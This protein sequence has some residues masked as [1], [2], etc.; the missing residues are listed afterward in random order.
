MKNIAIIPARGGSKRIPRKNIKPFMGKPIIAYSIEAALQSELFDEVM[1]STDDDEIA[2]IAQQYGAKVP[3]MRSADTANDYATTSD[4]I[5]EVISYYHERNQAFDII[6]C[7]Y[8]TAP[9]ITKDILK[10]AKSTYQQLTVSEDMLQDKTLILQSFPTTFF[11]DKDGNIV[12][13]IEG[14]NDYDGWKA[15]ID[16]VLEKVMTNE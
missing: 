11:V 12:D 8:A 16:E 5:N 13:S 3:F 14:S 10:K 9:F 7:I 4:V 2:N 15:K 1:V 6:S